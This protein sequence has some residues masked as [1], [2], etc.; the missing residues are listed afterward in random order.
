MEWEDAA[1]H[2]MDPYIKAD[3][4]CSAKHLQS[5][6]PKLFHAWVSIAISET[7]VWC[8][9]KMVKFSTTKIVPFKQRQ[10]NE[11]CVIF[12]DYVR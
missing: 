4:S 11:V 10:H 3:G 7:S 12:R 1:R 2:V 8:P 6:M 5:I 9:K